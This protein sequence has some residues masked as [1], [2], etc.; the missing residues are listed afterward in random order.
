M[1]NGE[2]PEQVEIRF[3]M[4]VEYDYDDETS[5]YVVI[6]PGMGNWF[7]YSE[8][9]D[10][11]GKLALAIPGTATLKQISRTTSEAWTKEQ[12]LEAYSNL[13]GNSSNKQIDLINR[14]SQAPPRI[15]TK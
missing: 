14:Y 15:L 7:A 6:N 5:R 2:T 3:G 9:I 1:E 8:I 4:V 11:D 13:I 12:V 10:I